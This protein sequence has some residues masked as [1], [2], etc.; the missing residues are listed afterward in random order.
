MPN[1]L[2]RSACRSHFRCKCSRS[3]RFT[4]V[5]LPLIAKNFCELV[6]PPLAPPLGLAFVSSAK[7]GG[8]E[9]RYQRALAI[10]GRLNRWP[11]YWNEIETQA[12]HSRASSIGGADNNIVA[13]INHGLTVLP[14]LMLTPSGLDTGGSRLAPVPQVGDGLRALLNHS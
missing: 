3:N 8:N 11:M 6:P 12:G 5:Y 2:Q 4:Q 9:T 10:N 13:D 14:I 1:R 7:S